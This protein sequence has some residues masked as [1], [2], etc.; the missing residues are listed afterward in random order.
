MLSKK[1]K[2]FVL[3]GMVALLVVTG[4]LNVVLNN[5]AKK[6]SG[7]N[8]NTVTYESL[9]AWYRADRTARRD[10]TM[11]YLQS[12]VD[13]EASSQEAKKAAE[14]EMQ[15]I[16]SNIKLE[17]TLEGLVKAIGF[18][19]AFV[20]NS[21]ENINVIIKQETLT[22]SEANRVLEVVMRE[23]SRPATNIIIVPIK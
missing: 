2:I 21:T 4:V 5:Q 12:I 18:E 17:S 20:T 1:K 9:F 23:T 13:S 15:Q 6:V 10:Q 16:T 14:L 11:L 22:D 3:V 7:G 19:D 8:D